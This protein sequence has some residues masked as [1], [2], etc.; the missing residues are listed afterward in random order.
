MPEPL[1]H[2]ARVA[3]DPPLRR[4]D[5][6]RPG[7]HLADPRPE[8][9]PGQP[10]EPADELEQLASLHP[11][12]EPWVL[13]EVAERGDGASARPGR[14]PRPATD[15]L[16]AVGRASPVRIRMVVVLPAPFGPSRPK[17][18]PRGTIE[19][20]PVERE[21]RAEPLRE[22]ARL[23]RR[24]RRCR[25]PSPRRLPPRRSRLLPA[26]DEVDDRADHVD[27]DDDE[28][29]R[30]ACCRPGPAARRARGRPGPRSSGR[31]G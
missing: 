3:T 12:V 29:P 17:T 22:R 23:D 25:R 16:P 6:A 31:A 10:V 21:D 1:A 7:E 4:A 8:L 9:R 13:V 20:E 2:P 27:E 18:E 28:Q 14:P 15:A 5:Q 30:R 26:G 11:A 24:P 19:V